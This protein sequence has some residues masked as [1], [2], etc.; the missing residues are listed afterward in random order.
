[1][2]IQKFQ[3]LKFRFSSTSATRQLMLSVSMNYLAFIGI[4]GVLSFANYLG[5]LSSQAILLLHLNI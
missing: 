4:L 3:I 1:M 2:I 5:A